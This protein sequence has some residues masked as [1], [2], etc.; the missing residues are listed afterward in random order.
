MDRW[1]PS[2]ITLSGNSCRL[3]RRTRNAVRACRLL[4]HQATTDFQ[5][6]STAVIPGWW[7]ASAAPHIAPPLF[8]ALYRRFEWCLKWTVIERQSGSS[9]V[10]VAS[11]INPKHRLKKSSDPPRD[12]S[13]CMNESPAKRVPKRANDSVAVGVGDAWERVCTST[14]S[15]RL[16]LMS[17][18]LWN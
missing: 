16:T 5:P 15:E 8:T 11:S 12:K 10:P 9:H 7:T 13:L 3:C 1:E 6:V 18:S 14:H 4:L 2:V 17:E